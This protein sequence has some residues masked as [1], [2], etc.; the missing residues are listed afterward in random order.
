LCLFLVGFLKKACVADNLAPLVDTYFAQPEAFSVASAWLAIVAY[1]V[2][3][4]CDFSGYSDMAIACAGLLGYQLPR[5]FSHPYF[6]S[7]I[8]AFWRRWHMSL[9][10]WLRDYLYIPLGGNRGGRFFVYRNLM[11]T[12]LL[13]G[14]WH[15]AAWNFL[16]WGGLHGLALLV[17]REWR[18]RFAE[19]AIGSGAARKLMGNLATFYWVCVCWAFFRAPDLHSGFIAAKAFSVFRSPGNEVVASPTWWILIVGLAL[20]HV[21]SQKLEGT[22]AL[23]R[24]PTWMFSA[25]YGCCLAIVFAFAPH[26]YL[27]FIYF[28]F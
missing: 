26:G 17:H 19:E 16:I 27:P 23:E 2:Q 18:S 22:G 15:G 20:A 3:I 8:T 28:Q 7:D 12:M 5:N 14:L 11:I 24:I 9:S 21:A 4:Y 1:T 25:A 10:G 13:G 6:A